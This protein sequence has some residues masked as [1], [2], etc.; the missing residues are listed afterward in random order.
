MITE[1]RDLLTIKGLQNEVRRLRNELAVEQKA[2][3]SLA[4]LCPRQ[5]DKIQRLEKEQRGKQQ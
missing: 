1:T 5:L 3:Q 2:R 4:D